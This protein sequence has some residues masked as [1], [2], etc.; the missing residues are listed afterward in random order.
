MH[1]GWW[2]LIG[3]LVLVALGA[4]SFNTQPR[5][6]RWSVAQGAQPIL[7]DQMT[8]DAWLLGQGRDGQPQWNLIRR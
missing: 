4:I 6:P 5:P 7:L 1:R 2:I 3:F 8:G